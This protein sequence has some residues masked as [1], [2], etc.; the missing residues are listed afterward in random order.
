[1]H[2]DAATVFG[3]S[4]NRDV[5]RELHP[6]DRLR[7]PESQHAPQCSGAHVAEKCLRARGQDGSY[8]VGLGAQATVADGENPTMKAVQQTAP[9]ANLPA[10]PAD[11]RLLELR[12]RDHTVLPG[13]DPGDFA[14]RSGL[15]EFCTH[16][17]A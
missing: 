15:A 10:A 5:D 3:V 12:Q 1:M 8:P 7:P 17:G 2:S 13:G 14:I 4:P 16:V 11:P 9:Q 6:T